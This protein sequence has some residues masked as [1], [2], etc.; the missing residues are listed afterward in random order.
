MLPADLET[1]TGELQMEFPQ[2]SAEVVLRHIQRAAI[3]FCRLSNYWHMSVGP[4]T[5][6]AGVNTYPL[7]VG[8]FYTILDVLSVKLGDEVI[9]L[10][11]IGKERAWR[12]TG[13]AELWLDGFSAGDIIQVEASV[14]PNLV[15]D[16]IRLAPFIERDYGEGILHGARSAIYRMPKEW[17]NLNL[18]QLH[19]QYF[20]QACADARLK[21]ASNYVTANLHESGRAPQRFF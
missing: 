7:S 13:I 15:Y 1:L 14:T 2:L 3:R 6:L 18:H 9:L 16:E 11:G 17:G 21:Q 19:E 12:Q 5:Y 10:D 20:N 4:V 8:M